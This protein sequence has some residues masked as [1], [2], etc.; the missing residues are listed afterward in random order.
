VS[1]VKKRREERQD[2]DDE[3]VPSGTQGSRAGATGQAGLREL[4]ESEWRQRLAP[5]QF[6]VTRRAGT[7]RPFTSPWLDNHEDGSYRCVGCDAVLFGS[8]T[9]F[10]SGS[11][12]PSFTGPAEVGRVEL[13]EDRSHGMTR[14]E[15][16]CR[17]C[18]AHLGHVFEDGPGPAGQRYCINGVALEFSADR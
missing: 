4:P 17:N 18:G 11:G 10:E 8:D 16:R 6:E 7:E 9:K 5:E 15:V 1:D 13:R 12:W 14:T 2:E 3:S